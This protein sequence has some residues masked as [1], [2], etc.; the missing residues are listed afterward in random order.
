MTVSPVPTR[1]GRPY[2]LGATWDGTG[3]NF[4]LFSEHATAVDLCLFDAAEP[5]REAR[6]IPVT[7]RTDQIWHV[8]LPDARPGVLYAYRVD[9]PYAPSEGHRFNS[10]K[11][12]LDPYAKAIAG[13]VTWNDALLG[14][15]A[16]ATEDSGAADTRDS[17]PFVP[18]CVVVETAFSW[19]DDRL[20]RTPWHETVIYEVHVKGFTARHPEIPPELRGT[21]ALSLIHI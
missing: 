19:G 9:G 6:R 15:E 13:Q 3:V 14:Y 5:A 4:A 16:Q 21:Y 1:P 18:K 17:A 10:A 7:E 2:P 11:V 20:L 8:Y 12:L